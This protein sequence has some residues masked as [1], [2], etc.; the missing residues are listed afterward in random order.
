MRSIRLSTDWQIKINIPLLPPGLLLQ[1][2][3]IAVHIL[4]KPLL[5]RI[6]AARPHVSQKPVRESPLGRSGVEAVVRVDHILYP[7]GAARFVKHPQLLRLL[8]RV[9]VCARAPVQCRPV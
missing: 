9:G 7:A 5:L 6:V 8:D 1:Q 3:R 4:T 2:L